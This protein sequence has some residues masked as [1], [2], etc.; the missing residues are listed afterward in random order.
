MGREAVAQRIAARVREGRL[1]CAEAFA[2]ARELGIPAAEVALAAE[3]LGY[4]IGW[5]QL[6]LFGGSRK[7]PLDLVAAEVPERLRQEIEAHLEGGRLP[8][9]SAWEIARRLGV[10]RI[11]VGRAADALGVRIS[12]CM[13]G[14][15]P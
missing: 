5:C 9:P 11:Q 14:C 8:C 6:G 2:L 15:F 7:E 12:R 10:E 3:A 13:L 4:R 1:P